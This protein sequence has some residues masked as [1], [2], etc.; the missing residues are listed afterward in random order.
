M[1]MNVSYSSARSNEHSPEDRT[2]QNTTR[3]RG[4]SW[5][6]ADL[7]RYSRA[8]P[9][10]PVIKGLLNVG[11]ILLIHGTEES[12]KSVMIAQCAESIANGKT[13]LKT[14]PV[15]GRW[16]VGIVETEMHPAM[17]GE[18]LSKMFPDGTAPE[19]M[20]FMSDDLLKEFRRSNLV[21]KFDIIQRWVE[22]LGIQ[23]LMIDTANDFFRGE[24]SPSEERSVGEFFDRLRSLPVD[25]RI[26]VRHDRKKKEI[27]LLAHSNELIRGSAEWKEDPETIV[28]IKRADKRTNEVQ[29][30]VG[31]LRYGIKPEPISLWFDAG[32]FR[33]TPLPPVVAVLERGQKTRQQVIAECRRRFGVAERLAETMLAQESQ[34]LQE[35]NSGHNRTY[36]IHPERAL[37]ASWAVFLTQPGG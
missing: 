7:I 15:W 27:D 30:E 8:N 25:A 4:N 10:Q 2:P 12:Y 37:E 16:Q 34:F 23:I 22:E 35:G 19:N 24:D 18:R 1:D 36:E 6:A 13:F 5:S 28:Y 33:L 29:M 20:V 17:M 9:P 26:I 3:L 31:K 32:C 21:M 14:W 11:D